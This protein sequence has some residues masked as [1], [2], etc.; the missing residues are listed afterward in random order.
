MGGRRTPEAICN[1]V[2][3]NSD[4]DVKT[5]IYHIERM[6]GGNLIDGVLLVL[7]FRK[8]RRNFLLQLRLELAR[9][10]LMAT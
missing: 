6:D 3:T 9:S 5:G 8:P 4:L 7:S 10:T 1:I 2:T